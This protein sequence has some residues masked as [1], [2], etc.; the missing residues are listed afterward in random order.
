MQ[1]KEL[2]GL[3][4]GRVGQDGLGWRRATMPCAAPAAARLAPSSGGVTPIPSTR[5]TGCF[6]ASASARDADTDRSYGG[7]S[8]DGSRERRDGGRGRGRGGGRGGGRFDGGRGGGRGGDRFQ[9]SERRRFGSDGDGRAERGGGSGGGDGWR[10]GRSSFGSGRGSGRGGGRGGGRGPVDRS[11]ANADDPG[12]VTGMHELADM[13]QRSAAAWADE[14]NWARL[15]AA[16]SRVAKLCGDGLDHRADAAMAADTQR[17]MAALSAAYTPQVARMRF[18]V[19]L[20]IPLY[21]VAKA[22]CWEWEE[23]QGAAAD[24][25]DADDTDDLDDADLGLDLEIVEEEEDGEE[26]GRRDAGRGRGGAGEFG[27][28]ASRRV[29]GLAAEL[30]R[31]LAAGGPKL[32]QPANGQDHSNL[33]WSLSVAPE[34]LRKALAAEVSEVLE[35]SGDLM[36]QL[37][38]RDL[39]SQACSNVL[40]SCARLRHA[41]RELLHHLTAAIAEPSL[42]RS[43]RSL[44][45]ASSLMALGRLRSEAGHKPRT[46]HLRQLLGEVAARLPAAPGE[47]A[48]RGGGAGADTFKPLEVSNMLWA[49]SKLEYTEPV[50]LR[51]LAAAAAAAGPRMNGQD[52]SNALHA[53]SVLSNPGRAAGVHT[54]GPTEVVAPAADVDFGPAARRLATDCQRRM[55]ST[56]G[57]FT[58]QD[59]AGIAL[60]LARLGFTDAAWYSAA[61]ACAMQPKF[62]GAAQ[63]SDCANLLTALALAGYKTAPSGL[64][65]GMVVGRVGITTC[66]N[67]IWSLA[68]LDLYDERL[69][70]ALE[71]RLLELLQRASRKQLTGEELAGAMWAVATLDGG[72][73]VKRYRDL[74]AALLYEVARRWADANEA[75][76]AGGKGVERGNEEEAEGSV[77]GAGPKE[78][79]FSRDALLRLWQA[80]QVLECAGEAGHDLLR[81]LGSSTAGTGPSLLAAVRRAAV[82]A[83]AEGAGP[84]GGQEEGEGETEEAP[85]PR[86]AV[87]RR[88]V[89]R[90]SSAEDSAAAGNREARTEGAGAEEG[91]SAGRTLRPRTRTVRRARG[92]DAG[93]Q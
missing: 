39:G 14:R 33:F 67:W 80:K 32:L 88:L 10:E 58:P 34:G 15:R 45:L 53:M 16:F 52:F 47:P 82:A 35:T 51:R 61:V 60:A 9:D 22:G 4:A 48:E 25:H 49:C 38:A 70:D 40:S 93:E 65:R 89:V 72:R 44:H 64:T 18:P 68:V 57:G 83:G 20:I 84:A 63:P 26:E 91:A 81:I 13:A 77:A 1:L 12:M 2:R 28:R 69:T 92:D 87:R 43:A 11:N 86:K 78:G 50:V 76:H 56:A 90:A 79:P 23:Q 41:P 31:R 73:A 5:N 29:R 66:A 54:G 24:R 6:V 42:T 85:A 62:R 71:A 46:A 36:A 74:A 59:V 75:N 55:S 21:A 37:A 17:A 19:D 8:A 3:P 30:L 7:R 27:S